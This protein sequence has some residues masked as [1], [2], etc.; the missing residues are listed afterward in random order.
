MCRNRAVNS[1]Q[2]ASLSPPFQM[3]AQAM[4]TPELCATY[5][6]F[7]SN[8]DGPGVAPRTVNFCRMNL[9]R[10][11]REKQLPASVTHPVLLR[12]IWGGTEN[13]DARVLRGLDELLLLLGRLL[14]E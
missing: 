8:C 3:K 11:L 10:L 1:G 4:S 6:T 5:R 7:R 12:W 2:H 13:D 9:R 14:G